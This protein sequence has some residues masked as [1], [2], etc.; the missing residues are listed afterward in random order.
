MFPGPVVAVRVVRRI[1]VL[2]LQ[3]TLALDGHD[4]PRQTVVGVQREGSVVMLEEFSK[5]GKGILLLDMVLGL[6]VERGL[7]Q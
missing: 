1:V 3:E 4:L 6:S 5:V 2:S 7:C